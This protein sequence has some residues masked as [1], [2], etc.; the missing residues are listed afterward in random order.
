MKPETYGSSL[1]VLTP[2][3]RYKVN[4]FQLLVMPQEVITANGL[5]HVE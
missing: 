2:F 5:P 1:K 3:N 4:L